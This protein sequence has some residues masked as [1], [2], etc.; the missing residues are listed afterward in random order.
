[1]DFLFLY[2]GCYIAL[3]LANIGFDEQT[4]VRFSFSQNCYREKDEKENVSS[5]VKRHED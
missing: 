2:S 5:P 1:M 3:D 4:L